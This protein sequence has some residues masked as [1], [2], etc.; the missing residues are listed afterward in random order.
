MTFLVTGSIWPAFGIV[1]GKGITG[2]SDLDTHQRRFDG[3]RNALWLFIIAIIAFFTIATQNY[4]F[5]A[6]AAELTSKLKSLSFKAILRQD[7]T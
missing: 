2:F 4:L 3:D 7:S 6:S 5:G 1:Y